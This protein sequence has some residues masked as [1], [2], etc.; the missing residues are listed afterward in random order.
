MIGLVCSLS[1]EAELRRKEICLLMMI[2]SSF[3]KGGLKIATKIRGIW[4]QQLDLQNTNKNQWVDDLILINIWRAGYSII[5]GSTANTC[6]ALV[7]RVMLHKWCLKYSVSS[8]VAVILW[9]IEMFPVYIICYNLFLS[10]FVV[11]QRAPAVLSCSRLCG[12]NI[13]LK[14]GVYLLLYSFC[15]PLNCFPSYIILCNYNLFWSELKSKYIW[16]VKFRP[17]ELY[18]VRVVHSKPVDT[19]GAP[20]ILFL[21]YLASHRK[22]IDWNVE[23]NYLQCL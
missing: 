17:R 11:R 5:C 16:R 10:L 23:E 1:G 14:H 13:I 2:S 12:I 22:S 4:M 20:L 8:A 6:S 15:E 9:K 19:R 7:F 21:T 3:L 18:E